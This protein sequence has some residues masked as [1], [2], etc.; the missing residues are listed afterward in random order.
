MRSSLEAAQCALQSAR[1]DLIQD[2]GWLA[3]QSCLDAIQ[4]S[5]DDVTQEVGDAQGVLTAIAQLLYSRAVADTRADVEDAFGEGQ[6][7]VARKSP[8][9]S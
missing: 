7:L 2:S 3:A 1:L 8:R 5:V 6:Q 4:S 9:A